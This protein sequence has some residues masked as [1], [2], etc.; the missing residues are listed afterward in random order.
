MCQKRRTRGNTGCFRM[1]L[2]TE[3]ME[4]AEKLNPFFA[5]VFPG[6]I[7]LQP[8]RAVGG[9]EA[10]KTPGEG[11]RSVKPRA[12]TSPGH[13]PWV[14]RQ[15]LR[16]GSCTRSHSPCPAGM[17]PQ[18]VS[19]KGD[20]WLSLKYHGKWGRSLSAGRKQTSAL[21]SGREKRR[22]Q[23]TADLRAR[24]CQSLGR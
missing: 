13:A 11:Q 1:G 17:C 19:L 22:I 15:R 21:S 24:N 2:T 16:T 12:F 8:L 5:L 20:F 23:G 10:R 6:K 3:D 18:M 4:T 14:F 7:C 9:S